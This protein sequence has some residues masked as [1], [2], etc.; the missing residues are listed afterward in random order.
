MPDLAWIGVCLTGW[1]IVSVCWLVDRRK[2]ATFMD[3][4]GEVIDD[5]TAELVR[6]RDWNAEL[7]RSLDAL[8]DW[9]RPLVFGDMA[10]DPLCV[11]IR[12]ISETR[13]CLT[14]IKA[15]PIRRHQIEVRHVAWSPSPLTR[16]KE[17]ELLLSIGKAGT[18]AKIGIEH[19]EIITDAVR[20]YNELF[21][22]SK[23]VEDADH[24][25]EARGE[26]RDSGA[27][28]SGR[29][30]DRGPR[31]PRQTC[32]ARDASTQECRDSSS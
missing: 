5:Y 31:S 13:I 10:R 27:G 17:A 30:D 20:R 9:G 3:A 21:H 4:Q 15:M 23:G 12:L 18:K 6:L 24:D 1:A 22:Q 2:A 19:L 14:V 29:R 28:S 7:K 11:A 26:D 25:Q 16:W 32:A 8:D